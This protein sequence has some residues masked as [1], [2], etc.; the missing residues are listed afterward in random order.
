MSGV[1]YPMP[2]P[3]VGIAVYIRKSGRVLL[4]L[5]KGAYQSGTWCAPGGKLELYE[6]F[7]DCA[8]RETLEECGLEVGALRF[9]GVH[10]DIDPPT[11]S[12]YCTVAFV[13]DWKAGEPFL[14][15]PEKF[16]RWAWFDWN[17][18]PEPLFISTRNFLESGYNPFHV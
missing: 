12:H 18:L 4:G 1:T 16:E 7:E 2:Y 6:G 5:R 9:A 15:E 10:N 13:A 14:V 8:R 17:A 11:G 3:G